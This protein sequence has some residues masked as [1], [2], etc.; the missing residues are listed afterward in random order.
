MQCY[1]ARTITFASWTLNSRLICAQWFQIGERESARRTACLPMY[2]SSPSFA[3]LLLEKRADES[4][5]MPI[6]G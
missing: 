3:F 2:F 1:L 6:R 5:R 4:Y